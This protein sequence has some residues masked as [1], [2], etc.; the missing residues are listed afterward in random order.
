MEM[1][2]TRSS[3][4]DFDL[5]VEYD[6]FTI[7]FHHGGEF[8]KSPETTYKGGLV[9]FVDRVNADM[10]S[11]IIVNDMVQQLGYS[12]EE[13]LTDQK[14]Y[15][16]ISGGDL[17]SGLRPLSNDADALSLIGYISVHKVIEVYV[18]HSHIISK[19]KEAS[20]LSCF[21]VE[22]DDEL[23]SDEPTEDDVV[24]LDDIDLHNVRVPESDED[25]EGF[26]SDSEAEGSD[27]DSDFIF[28]ENSMDDP[29]QDMELFR[30]A[31]DDISDEGEDVED[32]RD[33]LDDLDL[34]DIDSL[35]DPDNDTMLQRAIRMNKKKKSKSHSK[36][37]DEEYCHFYL[38]QTFGGK[39]E[40]KQ[41]VKTHAIHSRRQLHV[42][43][44]DKIRYRVVCLGRN[45]NM[46]SCE[47]ND[48]QTNEVEENLMP[49]RKRKCKKNCGAQEGSSSHKS[50]P[51]KNKIPHPTCPWVLHVSFDGAERIWCVTTLDTEHQCLQ[52]RTVSLCTVG[53]LAKELEEDLEEDPN[54]SMRKLQKNIQRRL[55]VQVTPNQ[56]YKAK[57][58]AKKNVVHDFSGQYAILREYC[59]EVVRCNPGTTIKIDVESECNP[60]SPT[61]QFKRIYVCLAPLR[62]G[63]K[64]CGRELL[65]LDGCFM[66]GIYPGQILTAVGVDSN[67]G[68]YP[69]AYAI[70]ESENTNSWTWFLEI[71]ADDL[72]LTSN[73][74]F[75]FM[76]DRQKVII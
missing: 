39:D 46:G 43:K 20:M 42:V 10:F 32:K 25:V 74:N 57:R 6:H 70:V 49:R 41:M 60:S 28:N 75:T 30:A 48:N 37:T 17:D 7:K 45:L 15:F 29:N 12:E 69:V 38:G 40:I 26:D 73:S 62:E 18:E 1:W 22:I 14:F 24:E 50:K 19:V 5:D 71:L 3:G 35:S 44:N 21:N 51:K 34:H 72:D 27:Y 65:G 13:V 55:Q 54:E 8:E 58:V 53:W 11:V 59:Q 36:E 47:N 4:D 9:T 64:L 23:E 61:R 76:S 31:V 2:D 16:R 66:K 52:T 33:E 67:N 56:I 68:I 63:F